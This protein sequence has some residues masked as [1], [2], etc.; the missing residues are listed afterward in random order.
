M[1]L[2]RSFFAVL[3]GFLALFAIVA[4]IWVLRGLLSPVLV[5]LLFAYIANPFV[6]W[7]ERCWRWPRLVTVLLVV[8]MIMAIILAAAVWLAPLAITQISQLFEMLPDYIDR[9]SR[10]LHTGGGLSEEVRERLSEAAENPE[11]LVPVLLSGAARGVGIFATALGR[12]TYVGIYITLL[13]VFFIAF[14]VRL[15]QIKAWCRQFLPHSHRE[16]VLTTVQKISD[17]AGVFLR[18]RLIIAGIVGVLLSVG[19][20][21]ADVPYWFVFAMATAVLN[22]VPYASVVGW[23]AV[24]LINGLSVDSL[25]EVFYALLWPTVVYTVVQFLDGWVLSPWLEGGLL[26]IHPV[27]VLFAVLAGGAVAGVL[28]MLMAIPLVAAW[29][30]CFT[31]V[32]KPRLIDWAGEH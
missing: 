6:N 13:V 18:A 3:A 14:S 16:E 23:L 28:G 24:L 22:I 10:V 9:L 19:W 17:A 21:F 26:R 30:I 1:E 29:Q 25:G 31:D 27:V 20:A 15:P 4:I 2:R 12:L 7:T 5:G 32:I 8:V 11:R